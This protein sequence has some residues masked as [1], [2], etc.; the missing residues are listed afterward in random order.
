[1]NCTASRL[2]KKPG[3]VW[4]GTRLTPCLVHGM[5]KK[6]RKY[7]N[8]PEWSDLANRRFDSA[9]ERRY[10]EQLLALE[11]AGAIADLK[12]QVTIPL[13][14]ANGIKVGAYRADA[15]YMDHG[16]YRVIDVKGL[17]TPLFRFKAKV[18]AAHYGYEIE[19]V[20]P[21]KKK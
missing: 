18:F 4:P 21:E 3:M 11:K 20:Y 6:E 15:T 1:M 19:V 10:C 2:C 13:Y 9:A 14:G 5:K 7:K 8:R 17:V 12:F 16:V